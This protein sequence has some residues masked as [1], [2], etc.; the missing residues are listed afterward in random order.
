MNAPDRQVTSESGRE[1]LEPYD[2]E[3]EIQPGTGRIYVSGTTVHGTSTLF[4]QELKQNGWIIIHLG[5]KVERRK[6]V[7][8]LSDKSVCINEP[9]SGEF[10]GNFERQDPA[11][12]VDPR[13]ELEEN[14]QKKRKMMETNHVYD[15]RVKRGPWTYKSINVD[16]EKDL[17]REDLLD[18]RT[19]KVRDKHCWM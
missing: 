11:I 6:V 12:R 13:K 7:L 10:T 14:M 2:I 17:S 19:R 4:T 18:I 16:S 8:V 1:S 3:Q 15:V 9:F 5:D